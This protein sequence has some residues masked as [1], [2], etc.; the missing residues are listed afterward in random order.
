MNPVL[1]AVC[2]LFPLTLYLKHFPTFI[3]T[4]NNWIER[5]IGTIFFFEKEN[6]FREK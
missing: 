3:G 1:D 4:L 6:H 5:K 2:F